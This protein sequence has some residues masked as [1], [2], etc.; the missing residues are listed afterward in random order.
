MKFWRII[1]TLPQPLKAILMLFTVY[2]AVDFISFLVLALFRQEELLLILIPWMFGGL[3]VVGFLLGLVLVT[4]FRGSAQAYSGMM[5]E[6]KPFGVDYS[7]S[8]FSKPGFL[9]F[10]GAGYMLVGVWFVVLSTFFAF[11]PRSVR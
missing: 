7:R 3:G 2:F 4:D 11:A 6:Y 10:F 9:R 8:P 5:K 1:K